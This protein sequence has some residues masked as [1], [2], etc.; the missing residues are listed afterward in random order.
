MPKVQVKFNRNVKYGKE[1]YTNGQSLAVSK[2][3]YEALFESG[4]IGR[5]DD[6]PE[7]VDFFTLSREELE[8]VK[9]DDLKAFLDKE[10]IEYETKAIK[11]DLVKLI[12][13][14]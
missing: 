3:E 11:E 14:E 2:S 12:L 8:K 10:G 1:R 5:V 7:D 6:L 13:G 9:N 4:V